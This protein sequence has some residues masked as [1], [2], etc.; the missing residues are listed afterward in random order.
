MDSCLIR[1]IHVPWPCAF[2]LSARG[3]WCAQDILL[4]GGRTKSGKVCFH[5][6]PQVAHTSQKG[7]IL[8]ECRE[9]LTQESLVQIL[10]MK[11]FPSAVILNV[12][13]L[14]A[15][16]S[17]FILVYLMMDGNAYNFFRVNQGL[18]T[19][20]GRNNQEGNLIGLVLS[21]YLI[22]MRTQCLWSSVRCWG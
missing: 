12:A 8:S 18:N 11:A 7:M 6:S 16:P 20:C 2:L 4:W 3:V 17:L 5:A 1:Q 21:R 22:S 9:Y 15:W 10:R 14:W 19:F 13:V